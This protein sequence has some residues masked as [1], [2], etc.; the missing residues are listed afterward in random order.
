MGPLVDFWN[1]LR[2]LLCSPWT[3][4]PGYCEINLLPSFC[5]QSTSPKAQR[6]SQRNME[7][8]QENNSKYWYTAL[9]GTELRIFSWPAPGTLQYCPFPRDILPFRAPKNIPC[10]FALGT[11]CSDLSWDQFFSFV[12]DCGRPYQACWSK[13]CQSVTYN[14]Q[15]EALQAFQKLVAKNYLVTMEV[16]ARHSRVK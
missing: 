15:K 13:D 7:T 1:G 8:E 16:K 10:Q 9:G 3:C 12:F 6:R 4:L 5:T 2:R 14:T 11:K